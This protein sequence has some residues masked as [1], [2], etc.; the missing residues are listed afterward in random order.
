MAAALEH[1]NMFANQFAGL[2][3]A[4]AAVAID[5]LGV[6]RQVAVAELHLLAALIAGCQAGGSHCRAIG[7][8]QALIEIVEVIGCFHLQA[9]AKT[10]GQ[11]PGQ[12]V[13]ETGLTGAILKIGGR[14]VAGDHAQHAILLNALD[15]GGLFTGREQQENTG[16]Q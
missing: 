2:G 1:Q 11:A 10:V 16:R 3:R 8:L 4:W 9:H 15:G 12:F 7:L 13:F 6:G 5:H 14:A